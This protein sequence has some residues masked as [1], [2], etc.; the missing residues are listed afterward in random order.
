M[1]PRKV[2]I[3][4]SGKLVLG[5]VA[6]LV[7]ASV[8]PDRQAF[9]Q[10]MREVFVRNFPRTQE[11]IGNI[12]IKD[13]IPATDSFEFSEVVSP[14]KRQETVHLINGGILKSDGF[15]T[16]TVSVY[17]WMKSG[18]FETGEVGV[19]LIPD[20]EVFQRALE[21]ADQI[22]MPIEVTAA[23]DSGSAG[24]FAGQGTFDVGFE[25]YRVLLYNSSSKSAQT[26]VKAYLGQ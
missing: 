20:E 23:V 12:T 16:L 4:I 21:D 22:L 14:I 9:S 11:V 18:T 13:P 1:P 25:R 2:I 6:V 3:G 17:G 15:T 5:V 10:Q 8:L 7:L 24:Y 26:F 19:L